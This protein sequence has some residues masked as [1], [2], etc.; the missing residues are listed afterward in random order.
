VKT[1][2]KPS[3]GSVAKMKN[4]LADYDFPWGSMT[5]KGNRL[6][7]H[8][9]TWDQAGIAFNGLISK[10]SKA[11]LLADADKKSLDTEQKGDITRILVPGQAPD[12]NDS[13]IVLE[14]NGS[15]QTNPQATGKY[16]WQ[17]TPGVTSDNDK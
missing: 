16:I 7:L 10:P 8:G 5:R 1:I 17:K 9:L 11:Y 6:Y 15:I 14:F 4:A 13:V 12:P 2:A 3:L